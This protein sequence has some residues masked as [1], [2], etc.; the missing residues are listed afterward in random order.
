L[1]GITGEA[2]EALAAR[3]G[4]GIGGLLNAT[5]VPTARAHCARIVFTSARIASASARS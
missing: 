1:A 2:T 3:L 4:A 5:F